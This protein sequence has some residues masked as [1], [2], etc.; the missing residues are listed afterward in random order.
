MRVRYQTLGPALLPY[1]VC[2]EAA[3]RRAD[4]ACQSI[5]GREID[6]AI[7]ALLLDTVAPAALEVAL[8]VQEE[9]AGRIEAAEVLRRSQLERARYEAELARRRYLKVDPDNRL[10]ADTLEADWNERLR[11]L[12]A[13][14]QEH[15][16]QRKAD[17]SLLSEE[18]R[19]DPC[20]GCR[21]PTRLE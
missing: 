5:R 13:L 11:R 2:E 1:Y 7:S 3:V 19:A 16:R 20:T 4:K 15:D 12:D 8:A 6:A 21:L 14:Q 17:Q 10:V 18:A 9:I